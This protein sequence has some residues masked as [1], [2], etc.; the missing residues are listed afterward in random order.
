[1]LNI[2]L[3]EKDTISRDVGQEQEFI[4]LN[5]DFFFKSHN[6]NHTNTEVL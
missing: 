4:D 5:A 1:M 6:I 3:G 2:L